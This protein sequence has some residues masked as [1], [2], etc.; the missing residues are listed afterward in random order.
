M[1]AM[2]DTHFSIK[3]EFKTHMMNN[4]KEK[5]GFSCTNYCRPIVVLVFAP[6]T[7]LNEFRFYSLVI[8]YHFDFRLQFDMNQKCIFQGFAEILLNN[9]TCSY[10]T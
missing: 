3:C 2:S 1:N 9:G 7:A 4:T 10:M 8:K 5:I 6:T